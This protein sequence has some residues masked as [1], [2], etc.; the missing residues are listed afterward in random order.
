[1][2]SW[3]STSGPGLPRTVRDGLRTM[4]N[5]SSPHGLLAQATT[6]ISFSL[7]SEACIMLLCPDCP[8]FALNA[9]E[10][11]EM[12]ATVQFAQHKNVHLFTCSPCNNSLRTHGH[13]DGDIAPILCAKMTPR[14]EQPVHTSSSTAVRR[15]MQ[16]NC[17][18]HADIHIP[19]RERW[20]STTRS[21]SCM[22]TTKGA[23][24]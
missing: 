5:S 23:R 16:L 3:Q 15:N 12:D 8:G 18:I 10:I 9:R 19:C 22:V 1:M 13:V 2:E 17:S 11:P 4:I 14:L 20:R 6:P 21:T 7:V 24:S